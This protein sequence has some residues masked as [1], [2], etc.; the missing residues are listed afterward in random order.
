MK[1]L[2][3]FLFYCSFFVIQP[4]QAQTNI[5]GFYNVENLFDTEDDPLIN[6]AEF[7]PAG[8][9]QWTPDR[10]FIKL[11]NMSSVL[12]GINADI[13][14]LAEVENRKVLEDLVQ[15]PNLIAKR[16]QII[17]F[18]MDDGRG[19]DVALLY[20]PSVFKPFK[21]VKLPI[22]DPREP[23]FKTRDILWV[24]G[25]FQGDTLHFIV[26]HWPSRSGGGKEDKR[27]LAAQV[28]RR[29]I[30]SVMVI[31]PISKMV[32]VG[33][34]NDDPN[35]KSIKKILCAENEKREEILVNASEPTFK[36][37]YGTLYYNGIWNLFDQIIISKNLEQGVQHYVPSSFTV[38]V[39]PEMLEKE[40]RY[41]GAPRRTFRS[42]Q[43]DENGFS[44]HLPVYIKIT[45]Q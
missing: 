10:Y 1:K 30:D 4:S 42:G 12:K 15:H 27:L 3:V 39:T 9:N 16:Y 38:Y 20:K 19:I 5:V 23:K 14:G 13:I 7:L 33:D 45:K 41:A 43:F 34:F 31:N 35:N 25:L 28:L 44:D 17:H 8:A 6:D 22:A 21:I 11:Q 18:D 26:N 32:M 36:K 2:F 37:G 24:K 40:G 29:A